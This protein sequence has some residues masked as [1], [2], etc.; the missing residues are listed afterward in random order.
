MKTIFK[1]LAI[2]VMSVALTGFV[3]CE[4]EPGPTP[5]TTPTEEP[6]TNSS[7]FAFNFQNRT[8]EAGQT[9]YFYPTA[10]EVTSDWATV[11]LLFENKTDANVNAYLKIEKFEGPDAMNSITICFGA[12]CKSGVCPWSY[13]PISLTPGV[14]NQLLVAFDYVPSLVTAK[15]VYKFT[16]GNGETLDDPQVMYLN[17]AAN[18]Q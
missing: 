13:G 14:N 10:E 9:V 6:V 11:N 15:T 18:A 4:P 2:A 1:Y 7:T 16:I 17:V 5:D 8:L 12:T 3:A